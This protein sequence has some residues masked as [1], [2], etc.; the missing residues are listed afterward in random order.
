[1]VLCQL[2][3]QGQQAV[4]I[5]KS[6][7]EELYDIAQE[8]IKITNHFHKEKRDLVSEIYENNLYISKIIYLEMEHI[9]I[10]EGKKL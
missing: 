8:I 10:K 4:N 6:K 7:E 1:M 9:R 2:N 5:M 3:G